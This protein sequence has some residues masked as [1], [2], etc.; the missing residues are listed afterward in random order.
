MKWRFSESKEI[1]I[2]TIVLAATIVGS[3]ILLVVMLLVIIPV[4]IVELLQNV[5]RWFQ[6]RNP[7]T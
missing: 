4:W 1:S 3:L 2:M 5:T 6:S 7:T